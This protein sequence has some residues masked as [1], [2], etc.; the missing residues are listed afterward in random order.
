MEK[1]CFEVVC[2][3]CN[4]KLEISYGRDEIDKFLDGD[5]VLCPVCQLQFR[6]SVKFGITSIYTDLVPLPN[7]DFVKSPRVAVCKDKK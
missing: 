1:I 6:F 3:A 5:I 4:S 7:K 2:P